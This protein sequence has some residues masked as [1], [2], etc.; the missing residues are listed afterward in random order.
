MRI[1]IVDDEIGVLRSLK[2]VLVRRGHTVRTAMRVTEALALLDELIPDVVLA[3][4]KMPGRNGGE[5]LSIVA[6]RL[7][8]ARRVLMSGYADVQGTLDAVF[9]P[10]PFETQALLRACACP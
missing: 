1:L 4:F 10:K 5:L 8:A 3:D 2:R 9:L 6:A 7:P